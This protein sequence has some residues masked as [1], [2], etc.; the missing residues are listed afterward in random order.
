MLSAMEENPLK[1]QTQKS[2]E[3]QLI[4]DIPNMTGIF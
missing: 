2:T 4:T 1:N 3:L